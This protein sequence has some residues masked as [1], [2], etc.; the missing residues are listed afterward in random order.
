MITEKFIGKIVV[1]RGIGSGVNIGKC[2]AFKGNQI[3]F[4]PNSF[5]CRRWE[6]SDSHGAFHSLARADVNGGEITLIK[7]ETIITD[8][9]QVVICDDK[10][11][12]ILKGLAK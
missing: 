2:A 12:D 1:V 7:N 11:K 3:L 5:F 8:V 9:A 10:V 4:C 6:Y